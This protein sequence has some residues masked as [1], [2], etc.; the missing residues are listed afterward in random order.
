MVKHEG[1]SSLGT[2]RGVSGHVSRGFCEVLCVCVV[3]SGNEVNVILK[4]KPFCIQIQFRGSLL[5]CFVL[6]FELCFK[7]PHFPLMEKHVAQNYGNHCV[8]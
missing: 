8:W 1:V 5:N 3:H 7:K 6:A 4:L 2:C